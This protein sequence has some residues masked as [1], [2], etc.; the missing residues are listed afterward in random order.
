MVGLWMCGWGLALA[1]DGPPPPSVT[2]RWKG[3][4]SALTVQAPDGYTVAED[5]PSTV[6]MATSDTEVV[7]RVLGASLVQGVPVGPVAGREWEGALEV[8]L[9]AKETG[10]CA[11]VTFALWA[12]TSPLPRGTVA[13]ETRTPERSDGAHRTAPWQADAGSTV[14]GVFAAAA[15]DGKRVLLDFGA[16]WCPPC[17]LLSAEVLHTETPPAI[18]DAVHL[19]EL[20]VD[21]P[22]SFP[23]KDRYEVGGYPTL[24]VTEPDGTEVSRLVGYPGKEAF[25]AW[26]ESAVRQDV[27]DTD[28]S[29]V[30]PG[31]VS[32]EQAAEVA[33]LMVQKGGDA[34]PWLARAEGV[35]SLS[36]RLARVQVSPNLEDADWLADNA[37]GQALDWVF[38]ALPLAEEAEGPAVLRRAIEAQLRQAEGAEAADLLYLMAELADEPD[39]PVLY[40]A[41]AAALRTDLVG[42]PEL[43]R[44]H[45]TWLAVLQE[46]SG[47]LDGA[48]RLL[49]DYA[50]RY[51]EEPT[52]REAAAKRLYDWGQYDASL[53]Q[54]AKAL[55][56]S[57]GDNRLRIA[58]LHCR[59]L[60]GL[61]REGDART[62]A[63]GVLSE[64]PAPAEGL[65]VRTG[66]YR[67][68][69]AACAA[70]ED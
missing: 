19:G 22:S 23:T 53:A 11:P 49:E 3:D 61:E 46:R 18:L 39:A 38:G 21:D 66:R 52:F 34:A 17:N 64:T 12:V 41:A 42:D 25:L 69:L 7:H 48:V 44:G 16:V 36:V 57:W 33:W 14:A 27:P 8:P 67:T 30:D 20:D 43:D 70:N 26:L 68:A 45:I 40:G 10:V 6:R 1:A 50:E 35:A 2:L 13:V 4:A 59:A 47:D 5:A 29:Q 32:P 60:L 24:I 28:F 62:F 31:S 15:V 55:E 58:E 56:V 37:P 63:E 54:S 9:C 51:P 65:K